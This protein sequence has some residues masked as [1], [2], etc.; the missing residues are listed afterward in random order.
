MRCS[1]WALALGSAGIVGG[2]TPAGAQGPTPTIRETV[3]VTASAVEEERERLPSTVTVLDR[4]E[5][6]ARQV[7]SLAELLATVPALPAVGNQK[8]RQ[9]GLQSM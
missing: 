3:V 2:T 6:E 5:I 1:L 9:A 8:A 4:A 7:P